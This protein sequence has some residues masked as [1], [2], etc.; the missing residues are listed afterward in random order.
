MQERGVVLHEPPHSRLRQVVGG[1]LHGVLLHVMPIGES[2]P[3][4][5]DI[6]RAEN[7]NAQSLWEALC[8]SLCTIEVGLASGEGQN[9]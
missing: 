3:S 9:I 7:K 2:N 5:A 4:V 1:M 8:K 6:E